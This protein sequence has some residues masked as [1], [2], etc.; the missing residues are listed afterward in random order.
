MIIVLE[1]RT[2]SG[3]I[4]IQGNKRLLGIMYPYGP[5]E[6]AIAPLNPRG[7][8]SLD[9]LQ[10]HLD[11]SIDVDSV[12]SSDTQCQW[13]TLNHHSAHSYVLRIQLE[14]PSIKDFEEKLQPRNQESC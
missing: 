3:M 8:L 14:R 9:P 1:K 11:F 5:E 4:P 13:I 10:K 2:S 12:L 6:Q 7:V